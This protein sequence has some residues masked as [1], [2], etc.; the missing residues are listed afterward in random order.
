MANQSSTKSHKSFPVWK[1]FA[2]FDS[3]HHPDKKKYR[4]CLVCRGEGSD[5][6]VS[7]GKD[8]SPAPLISHLRMHKEQYMEFLEAQQNLKAPHKC[9]GQTIIGKFLS[10]K[11]EAKDNFMRKFAIGGLLRTQCP[12]Q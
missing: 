5:K 2:H 10:T 1:F 4:I 6:A 11:S 12:L 9:S 8:S 3:A 7:V